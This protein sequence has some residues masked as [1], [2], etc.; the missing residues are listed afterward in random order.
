M[1]KHGIQ[2]MNDQKIILPYR[3]K[4]WPDPERLD[5]RYEAFKSV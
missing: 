4:D 5:E 3:K 2:E 1:L